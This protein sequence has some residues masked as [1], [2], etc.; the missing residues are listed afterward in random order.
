MHI[1]IRGKEKK[2]NMRQMQGLNCREREKE[3]LLGA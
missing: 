3:P 1:K 2:K